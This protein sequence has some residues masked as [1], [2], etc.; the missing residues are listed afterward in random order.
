[1]TAAV[2]LPQGSV[3]N[4]GKLT[5]VGGS[6]VAQAQFI[7][8]NGVVQASSAQNVNGTIEFVASDT[9][10]FGAGSTTA[11]CPR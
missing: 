2:T 6:V 10:S 11:A 5:A 4:E 1:M 7:N 9:A 8:Q 3:D